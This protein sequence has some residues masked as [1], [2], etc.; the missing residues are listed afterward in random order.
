MAILLVL[1]FIAA[2]LLWIGY[3]AL[4]GKFLEF[5][6][7]NELAELALSAETR[8]A[9]MS[10]A[11]K[12][13]IIDPSNKSERLRKLQADDSLNDIFRKMKEISSSAEIMAIISQIDRFDSEMLNEEENSILH[14]VDIGKVGAARSSY[15]ARYLPLRH[16]Y[17]ELTHRLYSIAKAEVLR[18][19]RRIIDTLV[20]LCLLL[21]GG[22][23]VL[24][25]AFQSLKDRLLRESRRGERLGSL[26]RFFSPKVAEL[27]L[28]DNAQSLL[29]RHRAEVT[30]LFIDLRGYTAFSQETEP[31]AVLEVLES[32]YRTVVDL[33]IKHRGTIGHLA[34]DGVMVFFNDPE[35]VE[36]H[37]EVA[38]QMAV[39]VRLELGAQRN[40]WAERSYGLDF[41]MGLADGYATIGGIGLENFLQYSVIGT[42]ANLASRICSVAKGG[43]ILASHRFLMAMGNERLC[44]EHVTETTL[45]GIAKPVQLYNLAS[46]PSEKRL[47]GR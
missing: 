7:T 17:N 20:L 24:V 25:M 23:V 42:V 15:I 37:Q 44:M 2:A 3:T 34:G 46:D 40:T 4:K 11:M 19:Q 47:R 27:L 14:L 18:E 9:E 16:H 6:R 45:K 12:G 43:Q 8:A 21:L 1:L 26:T 31:E 36:R 33:A 30:V 5:N 10:D 32:Y 28:S 41:G 29:K 13:Y 38:L 22:V 35:P 39:E